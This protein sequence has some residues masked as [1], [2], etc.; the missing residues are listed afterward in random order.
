[1]AVNKMNALD[2]KL[3]VP[4]PRGPSLPS[5][6]APLEERV[7]KVK[8][9]HG[10]KLIYRNHLTDPHYLHRFHFL[11]P[12]GGDSY[13][14]L[15]LFAG[16]HG[17]EVAGSLAAVRFLTELVERPE[18]A[19]GYEF[20]V[21]PVCNPTGY[22]DGTRH[23]RSGLDLN[24]EFWKNSEQ[25]EVQLLEKEILELN[26]DGFLSLHAD[27]TSDGLYGF[28]LGH[29]HAEHV[30]TPALEVASRVLPR[31]R[32]RRIDNLPARNSIVRKRYPGMLGPQPNVRRQPFEIVLETPALAP[33]PDQIESTVIA[34][35]KILEEYRNLLSFSPNL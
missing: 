1:M 16:I 27:D 30:L 17:D 20:F 12:E 11:G 21:Y 18:L 15:G 3:R 33:I 14:R 24:R 31:N 29:T 5:M 26:F 8:H 23:S 6:L 22:A 2:S 34:L 35:H 13:Q 9:L 32:R 10:Q 25:L 7:E 4:L 19:Q 28:A